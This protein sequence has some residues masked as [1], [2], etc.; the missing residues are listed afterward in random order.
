MTH[1]KV[2]FEIDV[3]C[4]KVCQFLFYI[5]MP[6]IFYQMIAKLCIPYSDFQIE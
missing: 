6:C 2:G 4:N 1:A 5:F 3:I